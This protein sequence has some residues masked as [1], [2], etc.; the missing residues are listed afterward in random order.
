MKKN[1]E[2][3]IWLNFRIIS[4]SCT[5]RVFCLFNFIYRAIAAVSN[6]AFQKSALIIRNKCASER[7]VNT[8]FTKIILCQRLVKYVSP[9][10]Q[11]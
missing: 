4:F 9:R 8:S 2:T 10:V 1:F 11:K 3:M 7:T 6:F 5:R